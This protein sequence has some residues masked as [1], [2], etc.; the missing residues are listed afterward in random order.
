ML[1]EVALWLSGHTH[2]THIVVVSVPSADMAEVSFEQMV[3]EVMRA[4]EMPRVQKAV[5]T[6]LGQADPDPRSL[7]HMCV[8]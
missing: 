5:V 8:L 2:P 7:Y 4:F 1:C 3:E 6:P